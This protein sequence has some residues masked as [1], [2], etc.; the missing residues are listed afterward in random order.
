MKYNYYAEQEV[1][2][3]LD[4]FESLICPKNFGPEDVD[5]GNFNVNLDYRK[6]YLNRLAY[7]AA[8]RRMLPGS[9]VPTISDWMLDNVWEKIHKK[10][11]CEL[12]RIK[13]VDLDFRRFLDLADIFSPCYEPEF[14]RE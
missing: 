14:F 1:L 13:C 3:V 7:K 12:N 10:S 4:F 11:H 6:I 2:F 9:M 5:S 8:E